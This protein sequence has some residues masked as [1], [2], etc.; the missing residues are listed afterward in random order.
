[1]NISKIIEHL[2]ARGT[3]VNWNETRD[4]VVFGQAD[5]EI[6]KLGVCWVATMQV[7]KEAIA[8]DIHFIISHENPF[9]HLATSLP[10]MVRDSVTHKQQLLKEHNICVYRC[11][12]VWDKIPEA[13]VRDMWAKRLG[14]TCERNVGSY[15]QHAT[16]EPV[17]VEALAKHIAHILHQD[18]ENGVY[19][20]G[21]TQ[22]MVTEI[23][24]GTGAATNIFEMLQQPCDVV[25]ACDDGIHNYYQGQ[26]AIDNGIPM[27][28]VNHAGCEI[29]GLKNMAT[30]LHQ[31]F[32]SI[33][34]EYLKEGYDI[35]Y[36]IDEQ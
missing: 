12:D 1:M 25:I 33:T 2:E 32:P 3:W 4:C 29:A 17:S 16:I 8:K 15:I 19:V 7:I 23:G 24:L 35:H 9:Y 21:D 6:Q 30:Y 10:S 36:Y 34:C 31:V 28:V 27:I 22:K 11:H 13:G 18:G 20:F 26:Y 5:I 14:F